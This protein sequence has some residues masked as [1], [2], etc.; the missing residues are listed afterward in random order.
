ME[1][2]NKEKEI[3]MEKET[4]EFRFQGWKKQK[5]R[6]IIRTKEDAEKKAFDLEEELKDKEANYKDEYKRKVERLTEELATSK[7]GQKRW[8]EEQEAAIRNKNDIIKEIEES[9]VSLKQISKE[10]AK[11]WK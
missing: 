5:Q 10:H 11:E 3:Q 4:Y 7:K 9:I 1:V 2:D 8:I 6:E